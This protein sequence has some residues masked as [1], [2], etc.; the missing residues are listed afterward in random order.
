MEERPAGRGR[1]AHRFSKLPKRW[2]P[3]K[4]VGADGRRAVNDEQVLDAEFSGYRRMW[5]ASGT[6]PAR[7]YAG[8]PHLPNLTPQEVR[9][10]ARMFK[11][12]TG[13]APDG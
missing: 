6:G 1:K 2:E 13:V 3:T 11:T 5:A 9:R 10:F 12:R 7:K 8:N 4:V